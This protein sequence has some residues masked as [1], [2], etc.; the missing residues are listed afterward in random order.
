MSNISL[1]ENAFQIIIDEWIYATDF[2]VGNTE[3]S[4]DYDFTDSAF[5]TDCKATA[6][7]TQEQKETNI[8]ILPN[9]VAE[10]QSRY[11]RIPDHN[12]QAG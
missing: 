6:N 3:F 9:T 11:I 5:P 10:L 2:P 12:V 1:D 8:E 7:E 4:L